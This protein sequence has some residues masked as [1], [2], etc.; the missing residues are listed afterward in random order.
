ME[1]HHLVA[2]L[3]HQTWEISIGGIGDHQHPQTL[4]VASPSSQKDG[5]SLGEGEKPGRSRHGYHSDG[6]YPHGG[7][8]LR[9]GWIPQ[10]TNLQP[11]TPRR[12]GVCGQS[13]AG[14]H[15]RTTAVEDL[16]KIKLTT[17]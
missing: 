1:L 7:N 14:R 4:R 6:I 16:S 8:G 12:N 2:I 17:F 5:R 11:G 3:C 13:G 10:A 9:L 15:G